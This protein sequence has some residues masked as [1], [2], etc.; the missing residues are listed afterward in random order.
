M[1]DHN[2]K[3]L[4]EAIKAFIDAMK[5]NDNFNQATIRAD[6]EKMVGRDITMNTTDVQFKEGVLTISLNSAAL[7]QELHMRRKNLIAHINEFY[8]SEIVKEIRLK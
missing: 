7:R 2:T 8:G 5:W 6:W 1:S 3:S 4:G